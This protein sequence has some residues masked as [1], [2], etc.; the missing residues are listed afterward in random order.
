[1]ADRYPIVFLPG[2]MGSRLYFSNSQKFWDP[3]STWRMLRWMPVWPFR[4]D[5]DN[6]QELHAREPAGVV[7]DPLDDSVDADGVSHGWGG[8]IWSY[9]GSYLTFLRTLAAGGQVF[10]VGYDWRQDIQWLGEYAADKLKTCLDVTG[11][12]RLWVATHSMGGLVLRA[13]FR[14]DPDLVGRIARVLHVCQPSAGAVVLYRRCFTGMVSGL[15][16]GGGVSDRAFRFLLGTTRAA[17]T[18]NMSGL[19]G[20]MELMPSGYFPADT[21]GRPWNGDITGGVTHADLYGNAMSPPGLNDLAL[22]LPADARA[23]LVERIQ[24]VADFHGWLGAPLDPAHPAPETWLI[25]GT[26]QDT[27]TRIDFAGSDPQPGVTADGD[28]TVPS[29]S[30]TA[31]ALAADRQ[32]AVTGLVHAVACQDGQVQSQ[33][34]QVF[35]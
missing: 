15:D 28:G 21:G 24:D 4:S 19:P 11:A 1:M 29:L 13:A 27:E 5:D 8:V 23:D 25:Y 22:Q 31:L 30:A 32:F 16:G 10:A 9:Y 35:V 3:D 34:A 17:F 2:V 18:G 33:S 6:R 20:A 14:S 12:E 7:I 26:G